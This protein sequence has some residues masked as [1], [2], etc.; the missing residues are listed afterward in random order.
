M[1]RPFVLPR[2]FWGMMVNLEASAV[3]ALIEDQHEAEGSTLSLIN[4]VKCV[5]KNEPC[6]LVN[7]KGETKPLDTDRQ[8]E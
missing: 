1:A 6:I 5:T 3:E 4:D 7:A 8:T 2:S